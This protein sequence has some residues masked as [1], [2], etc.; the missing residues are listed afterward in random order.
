MN[1]ASSAVV[2]RLHLWDLWSDCVPGASVR[3]ASIIADY[4]L[5]FTVMDD[6]AEQYFTAD[7]FVEPD[8]ALTDVVSVMAGRAPRGG[9][10]ARYPHYARL[11]EVSLDLR[12]RILECGA[13]AAMFQLFLDGMDRYRRGVVQQVYMSQHNLSVSRETQLYN[14]FLNVAMDPTIVLLCIVD[15]IDIGLDMA[16]HPMMERLHIA[17]CRISAAMNDIISF[18]KEVQQG[19]GDAQYHNL[20]AASFNELSRLQHVSN[21]LELAIARSFDFH[22][23]EFRDALEIGSDVSAGRPHLTRYVR[24]GLRAH[25]SFMVWCL[26][27]DRYRAAMGVSEVVL[28]D[29]RVRI[30]WPKPDRSV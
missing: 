27:A 17:L 30:V 14:R 1:L 4:C 9:S 24:M 16:E 12:T 20:V 15:G 18:P 21:P 26:S 19:F 6:I 22:N 29:K 10:A 23:N 2:D 11:I 8:G 7:D 3:A 13:S 28:S 5:L 25:R